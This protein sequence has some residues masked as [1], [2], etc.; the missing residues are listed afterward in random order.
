MAIRRVCQ[1]R[2]YTVKDVK[3]VSSSEYTEKKQEN[4]NSHA[5]DSLPNYNNTFSGMAQIESILLVSSVDGGTKAKS[6]AQANDKLEMGGF[7][8]YE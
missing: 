1:I 2:I 3:Y 8:L 6:E 7:F 5:V 4:G